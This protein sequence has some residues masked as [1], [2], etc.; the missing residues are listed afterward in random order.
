MISTCLVVATSNP[1]AQL[2]VQKTCVRGSIKNYV[3]KLC[4]TCCPYLRDRAPSPKRDLEKRRA[5][6]AAAKNTAWREGL[7][8]LR[9]EKLPPS[10]E[11]M[12]TRTPTRSHKHAA[13]QAKP[14]TLWWM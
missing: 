1:G 14:R 9:S 13:K 5:S 11:H 12:N 6:E 7:L 8:K 10:S 2:L 3:P 4:P